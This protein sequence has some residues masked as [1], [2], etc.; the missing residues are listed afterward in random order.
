M[1]KKQHTCY[2]GNLGMPGHTHLKWY[3]QF[4]EIFGIYV[5]AKTQLHPS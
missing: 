3:N 5:Q 1:A 2:L 4:E